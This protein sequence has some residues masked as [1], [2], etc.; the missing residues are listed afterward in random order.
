[1]N[2]FSDAEPNVEYAYKKVQKFLIPQGFDE[3]YKILSEIYEN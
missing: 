3:F 1:M 2:N